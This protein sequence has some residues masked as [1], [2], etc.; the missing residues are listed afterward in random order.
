MNTLTQDL[1]DR[2]HQLEA[3]PHRAG[4][5]ISTGFEALDRLL[6]GPGLKRGSLTEWLGDDDGS[7]AATLALTVAAHVLQ[8]GGAFVVVDRVGEFYPVAAAGLGIPLER[9]V[10]V[11]PDTRMGALWTWEQALRCPGVA[12]T[13]GWIDA[14]DDRLARRLQLAVEAGGGLGFI[15]RDPNDCSTPTW[16]TTRLGVKK[17]TG[18]F[19]VPHEQKAGTGTSK[20]RSQSPFFA[21]A[22]SLGRRLRISLARGPRGTRETAIELELADETSDEHL[23][24]ELADPTAIGQRAVG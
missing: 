11:Q 15:L 13:F 5:G 24:S 14:L 19:S 22:D 17:G 7:G 18:T 23:V 16:A 20:T 9:T 2:I 6:A 12:V 21:H 8:R 1:Q 3:S 10:V 4:G